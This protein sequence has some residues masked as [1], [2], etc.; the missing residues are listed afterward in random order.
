MIAA[1]MVAMPTAQYMYFKLM[2]LSVRMI[3]SLYRLL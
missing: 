3:F 1:P 2:I